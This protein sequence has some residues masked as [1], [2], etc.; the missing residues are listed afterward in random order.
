MKKEG[1]LTRSHTGRRAA[2][3]L[4]D[5]GASAVVSDASTAKRCLRH[6]RAPPR[7]DQAPVGVRRSKVREV[8]GAVSRGGGGVGPPRHG[9]EARLGRRG[10]AA[11]L[12]R[13][14]RAAVLGKRATTPGRRAIAGRWISWRMRRCWGSRGGTLSTGGEGPPARAACDGMGRPAAG[15]ARSWRGRGRREIGRGWAG[16]GGAAGR[17]K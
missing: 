12:G 14:G 7:P 3:D 6:R 17:G 2:P 1:H 11:A 13:R 4:G 8:E 16:V 15:Q 10:R 5:E 9:E